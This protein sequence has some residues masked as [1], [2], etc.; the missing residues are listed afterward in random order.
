MTTP[1]L[2]GQIKNEPQTPRRNLQDQKMNIC[3]GRSDEN[4]P[5]VR[6]ELEFEKTGFNGF[7]LSIFII[8]LFQRA[9]FDRFTNINGLMSKILLRFGRNPK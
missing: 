3:N 4:T 2:M 5:P 7:R 6:G 9:T 1:I 8:Y